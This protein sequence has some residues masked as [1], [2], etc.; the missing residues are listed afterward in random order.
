MLRLRIV[1]IG[2]LYRKISEIVV[3]TLE[4]DSF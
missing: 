1:E 2:Q 3:S 4:N